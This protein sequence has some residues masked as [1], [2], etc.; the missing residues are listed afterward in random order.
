MREFQYP[1]AARNLGD[2]GKFTGNP[3]TDSSRTPNAPSTVSNIMACRDVRRLARSVLLHATDHDRR[4]HRHSRRGYRCAGDL[5]HR[6]P[7]IVDALQTGVAFGMTPAESTKRS[8]RHHAGG[9]TLTPARRRSPISRRRPDPW[10]GQSPVRPVRR[11]SGAHRSAVTGA[12][13]CKCLRR[14]SALVALAAVRRSAASRASGPQCHTS[15]R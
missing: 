3:S 4:W 12:R 7:A 5:R 1:C 2:N 14:R 15:T 6:A 13:L 9:L 8:S 10:D 11:R